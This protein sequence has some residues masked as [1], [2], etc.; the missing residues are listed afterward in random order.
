VYFA[1]LLSPTTQA[2]GALAMTTD[3]NDFDALQ[4]VKLRRGN[5]H[6]FVSPQQRE[7][8]PDSLLITTFTSHLRT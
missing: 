6:H 4:V 1:P 8:T 2:S 5:Q 7:R 3:F